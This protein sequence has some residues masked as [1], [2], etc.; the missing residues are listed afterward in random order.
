MYGVLKWAACRA[1]TL[2]PLPPQ[3]RE[4]MLAG[5]GGLRARRS[6]PAGEPAPE[7]RAQSPEPERSPKKAE[8]IMMA[9]SRHSNDTC[10]GDESHES[11]GDST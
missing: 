1:Q 4:R 6:E 5:P 11:P 3:A 9:S 8:R 10:R 2:L 7:P